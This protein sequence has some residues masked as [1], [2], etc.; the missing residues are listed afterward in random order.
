MTSKAQTEGSFIED[1]QNKRNQVLEQFIKEAKRKGEMTA[2]CENKIRESI[3]IRQEVEEKR[4]REEEKKRQM[5]LDEALVKK[6]Q[7]D[8]EK[9][10]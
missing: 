10:T 9:K 4:L 8:E 5:M 2:A 1:I 6:L 3:R 7:E